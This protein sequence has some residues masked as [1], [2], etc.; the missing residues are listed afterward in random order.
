[1]YD[2]DGYFQVVLIEELLPSGKSTW[3]ALHPQLPGCN[4]AAEDQ[5]DALSGLDAAR[6][7]WVATEEKHGHPVPARMDHP[8]VTILYAAD[9]TAHFD[10]QRAG[11]TASQRIP[12]TA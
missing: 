5:G 10:G 1:M 2:T 12:M 7:A 3:L 8:L 9:P 11:G 4:A 6:E